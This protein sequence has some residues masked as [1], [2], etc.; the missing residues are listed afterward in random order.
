MNDSRLCSEITSTSLPVTLIDEQCMDAV[1]LDYDS[2]GDL[3]VDR[4]ADV[5]TAARVHASPDEGGG[6]GGTSRSHDSQ[7][8]K[9]Q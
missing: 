4:I 8:G 5:E 1:A 2:D 3:D 9:D 6:E 7:P